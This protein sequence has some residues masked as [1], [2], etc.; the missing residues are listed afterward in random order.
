MP[1]PY[2]TNE[3]EQHQAWQNQRIAA[4]QR[5][6][7]C[8]CVSPSQLTSWNSGPGSDS[9]SHKPCRLA[10][11]LVNNKASGD[12]TPQ[13]AACAARTGSRRCHRRGA[14]RPPSCPLGRHQVLH[15]SIL[16]HIEAMM[17]AKGLKPHPSVGTGESAMAA[18]PK[19]C[20]AADTACPGIWHLA[21]AATLSMSGS[22]SM[23]HVLAGR[24]WGTH[25]VAEGRRFVQG[26][27]GALWGLHHLQNIQARGGGSVPAHVIS[28]LAS[29]RLAAPGAMPACTQD[30]HIAAPETR[31]MR[32]LSAQAATPQTCIA[33]NAP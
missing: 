20:Q 3:L 26:P 11:D 29:W 17:P 30:E 15:V 1:P 6:R 24:L 33:A 27:R 16:E 14:A 32:V 13:A 25:L 12:W 8:S 18:R 31:R 19:C 10:T 7:G 4:L 9:G 5:H 22:G 2:K 21:T 23:L 28:P